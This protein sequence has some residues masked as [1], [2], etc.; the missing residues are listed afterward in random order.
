MTRPDMLDMFR[1]DL[2]SPAC[3]VSGGISGAGDPDLLCL[4]FN[5]EFGQTRRDCTSEVGSLWW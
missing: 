5:S 2:H 1:P 3:V 4:R